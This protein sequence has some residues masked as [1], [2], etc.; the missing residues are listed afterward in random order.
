M[1]LLQRSG[2]SRHVPVRKVLHHR[3]QESYLQMAK[4]D[5]SNAK[6]SHPEAHVGTEIK[7]TKEQLALYSLKTNADSNRVDELLKALGNVGQTANP[8]VKTELEGV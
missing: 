5:C 4:L 6:E 8:A 1:D 2:R 7:Y 3:N